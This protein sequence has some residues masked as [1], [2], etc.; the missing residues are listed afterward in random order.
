M[1]SVRM[2]YILG[3]LLLV[4]STLA[5][6]DDVLGKKRG[7][8]GN[9][10]VQSGRSNG[11]RSNDV[12]RRDDKDKK[13][14][15]PIRSNDGGS[16]RSGG[17]DKKD[18]KKNDNGGGRDLN[19]NERNN[20]DRSNDTNR[21][22]GG[23]QGSGGRDL[24]R[25]ERNNNDRS[26]DTNRSNGGGQGSG[27]RDLNRNERN[28]NDRNNDTN[29]SNG[30]S[31]GS[32]GRDLNRN[33]RDRTDDVNRSND[34][35]GGDIR[36]RRT[37][38]DTRTRTTNGSSNSGNRS[39]IND[40]GRV[41]SG[42]INDDL[43]QKRPI[44]GRSGKANYGTSSNLNNDARDSRAHSAPPP[45]SNSAP[46]EFNKLSL[47]RQVLREDNTRIIKDCRRGY[48]SY[49]RRWTDDWFFYPHYTFEPIWGRSV[50]SPFYGYW[51]VPGYITL[52][53]TPYVRID[54]SLFPVDD[55]YYPWRSAND[56]RWERYRDDY[57]YSSN[58]YDSQLD[59]ALDDL[60]T[61]FEENDDYL[62][63]R[64]VGKS[65][66]VNI[67]MDEHYSYSLSADD[68][69]DMLT[70]LVWTTRT[71]SYKIERVQKWR[72]NVRVL[73]KHEYTDTW[74]RRV[75]MYHTI[76]LQKNWSSYK[77]VDFGTSAYRPRF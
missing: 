38:I 9:D 65:G 31:Q 18:D 19:R 72:D 56:Y 13:D 77:I 35:I 17:D 25:N 26:N 30:G 8:G 36:T 44:V 64:L 47:G 45:L 76:R 33:E 75:T 46:I 2:I 14:N 50:I 4:A 23:G 49:D 62:V 53:R 66:R 63:E 15:P 10:S 58:R 7:G 52:S 54:F 55:Y 11:S 71:R 40:N 57:Y 43:L 51:H 61:A 39:I 68:F 27:G 28:N 16:K 34:R 67:Y 5:F 12:N 21:S 48:Y 20:N 74:G 41:S 37:D 42:R 29:R 22:N 60:V 69:A 32:G 3:G 24:N 70:D 6:D 1:K 73:A 59:Y